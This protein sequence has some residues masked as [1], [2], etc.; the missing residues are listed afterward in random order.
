MLKMNAM[1]SKGTAKEKKT[2]FPHRMEN[3][4]R[5]L[6]ME[7]HV[8]FLRISMVIT[9]VMKVIKQEK[10]PCRIALAQKRVSRRIVHRRKFTVFTI[11]PD[12]R[13]NYPGNESQRIWIQWSSARSA[14]RQP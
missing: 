5:S 2:G 7:L 6:W 8:L 14:K 3:L 10:S 11:Y 1:D 9:L 4:Y 12:S 13:K